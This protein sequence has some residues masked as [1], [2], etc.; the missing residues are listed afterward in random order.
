MS[1]SINGTSLLLW[2]VAWRGSSTLL[3]CSVG[4]KEYMQSLRKLLF[5]DGAESYYKCDNWPPEGDRA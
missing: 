5:L 2:D 1:D 3:C 4:A